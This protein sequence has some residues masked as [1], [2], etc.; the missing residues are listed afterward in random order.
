MI[1]EIIL[2]Y[3]SYIDKIGRSIDILEAELVRRMPEMSE[4]EKVEFLEILSEDRRDR[5]NR[6]QI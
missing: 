4:E 2:M 3:K 6:K 1:E 5:I